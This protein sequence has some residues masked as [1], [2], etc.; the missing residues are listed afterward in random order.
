MIN[1]EKNKIFFW[2][3]IVSPHVAFLVDRLA[4]KG[5]STY[6][7][8]ESLINE[9]RK[10]L[11]WSIPKLNY[12]KPVI[13]K[14]Q[15]IRKYL[16]TNSIHICQGLIFN[17]FIKKVQSELKKNN[18]N[19]WLLMERVNDIGI[20]GF[21]KRKLYNFLFFFWKNKINGILAIGENAKTWYINRGID[22]N[23]IFSF[24]YFLNDSILKTKST[25]HLNQVFKF[26]FVGELIK[27]K[28]LKLLIQALS[29]LKT[30]NKFQLEVI[31]DGPE[32]NKLVIYGQ[33]VLP[34]KIKWENAIAMHDV[35]K[36]ISNSDCLVL[37]SYFDGWGA[38]ISESL[39]VGTPVICSDQCGSSIIVKS[40][41]FGYI[42]KNDNID[43]LF[44]KLKKT[45]HKGKVS[46]EKR[47]TIKKWAS[48]LGASS[49]ADYLIKIL[50]FSLKIGKKPKPPWNI[51]K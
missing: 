20:K 24:A 5:L 31:G 45:I 43:D 40:S 32:K 44:I 6:L 22:K 1:L 38:V 50:L 35:P 25:S 11:G 2:Q 28:N 37:S 14:N 26:I 3:K 8:A 29:K 23:K 10:S 39:M 36:K 41:N 12:T 27:R 30:K 4:A 13:L 17:G 47:K 48:C 9:N 34:N 46:K 7:I 21:F 33:K 42:F 51:V 15:L 18:L 49:G 19:H 16:S